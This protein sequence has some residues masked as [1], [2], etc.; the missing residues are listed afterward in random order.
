[1][2]YIERLRKKFL[3]E[4][5]FVWALLA[6]KGKPFENIFGGQ[7]RVGHLVWTHGEHTVLS[8]RS[9]YQ[10]LVADDPGFRL[11]QP[12]LPRWIL[13]FSSEHFSVQTFWNQKIVFQ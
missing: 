10:I 8:S 2:G 13:G 5:T 6:W 11:A 12:A 1:M 3:T 4:S 9:W 7:E